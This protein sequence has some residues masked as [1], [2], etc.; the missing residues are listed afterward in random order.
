MARRVL[1]PLAPLRLSSLEPLVG[2]QTRYKLLILLTAVDQGT[3]VDSLAEEGGVA[4]DAAQDPGSLVD[5]AVPGAVDPQLPRLAAQVPGLGIGHPALHDA[6][7]A[8]ALD[9]LGIGLALEAGR[10]LTRAEAQVLAVRPSRADQVTQPAPD[11][12]GDVLQV[13][14]CLP[15]Q[16][17]FVDVAN[18]ALGDVV[19]EEDDR[20]APSPEVG[21]EDGIIQPVAGEAFEVPEQDTLG[22]VRGAA[23][24]TGGVLAAVMDKI[25]KAIATDDG[26]AR[27]G[28]VGK[29]AYQDQVVLL[30][31]L[32]SHAAL[33]VDGAL[34]L[35]AAR[36]AE[37][38][39][40]TRA[41]R[42]RAVIP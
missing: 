31:V 29:D 11:V 2:D 12:L 10:W 16:H 42:K 7:C 39:R 41:G 6:R 5:L 22:G 26:A 19:G 30:A 13:L 8:I 37:V 23:F 32:L 27:S 33:L 24:G 18:T 40:H 17:G 15:L 38:A 9:A 28:L 3:S 14:L 25:V 36:V 20:V 35:I 34:L 4:A 1:E 21:L